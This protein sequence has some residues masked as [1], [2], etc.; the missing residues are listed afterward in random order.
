M[1]A[2]RNP[3]S[4]GRLSPPRDLHV[5][6][7]SALLLSSCATVSEPQNYWWDQTGRGRG[8]PEL[9]SDLSGCNAVRQQ[10]LVDAQT[11]LPIQTI[12]T[13]ASGAGMMALATANI[14]RAE[15]DNAFNACMQRAGWRYGPAQS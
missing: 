2:A 12:G 11:H 15:A 3:T 5:L 6:V 1:S 9:Q 13:S 8:N 4:M 14:W 10:A 7:V